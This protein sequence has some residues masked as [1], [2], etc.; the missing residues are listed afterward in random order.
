MSRLQPGASGIQNPGKFYLPANS[1]FLFGLV[2]IISCTTLLINTLTD[3][4]DRS[5]NMV[6]ENKFGAK[7]LPVYRPVKE[8]DIVLITQI[9]DPA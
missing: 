8:G 5:A 2:C 1:P 7:I 9:F 4:R 3:V 6:C